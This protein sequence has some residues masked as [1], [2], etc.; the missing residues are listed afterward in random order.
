MTRQEKKYLGALLAAAIV[1]LFVTAAPGD[2]N[3]GDSYKMHFPQLPRNDGWDVCLVDQWL[4]ADF[5]CSESGPITDIHIWFSFLHDMTG[6]IM[7]LELMIYDQSPMGGGPGNML[8]MWNNQGTVTTRVYG[9]G[10]QGFT[11]PAT[12]YVQPP[13][14]HF[15]FFQLNITDIPQPFVQTQGVTYWLVI[16]S[17]S[18]LPDR[19]PG[20]KT[21]QSPFH[22]PGMWS[23]DRIN[24]QPIQLPE[25]LD[26]AFVITSDQ[27]Q[28]DYEFGDA[29]ESA[30][31]YPPLPTLG[32]FP[33]CMTVGPAG[34]I[35]HSNFGAWLGPSFDL[36]TDGNA[37]FCPTFT[38]NQYDR[39]ECFN[40]GDAGLQYPFPYTIVGPAGNEQIVPCP[41]SPGSALGYRCTNA[42]WGQ[43]ID[44]RVHNTMP[45]QAV[46]YVNVLMDWDQNGVWGGTSMCPQGLPAPEH[47]LVNY[48]VPNPYD[49][50]LSSLM[51][52]GTG[53]LIG[54][55][56]GYVWARITITDQFL[57]LGW[58]GEG[59]FEDGET[60]D[61]LLRVDSLLPWDFGDAPE[62][63][64]AYPGFGIMGGFPTCQT[65]G[66]SGWIRHGSTD[67][68]AWFGPMADAE[69]DGNAGFCPVFTPNTYDRD[70]CFADGDAGL[71]IP[72]SYTIQGPVGSESF[73]PCP[74]SLGGY[75][76]RGCTNAGWGV[77]LDIDVT[78]QL[79]SGSTAF[80]NVLMDWNQDGLWSG[81]GSCPFVAAPEHML[82]NFPIPHGFSGPLSWLG[83]PGF[84]IGPKQS[85]FVWA[86]FSITD[87][88]VPTPWTGEGTFEYGETEDYLFALEGEND[89]DF[90]DLPDPPYPTLA[91]NNGA[92]HR[93]VVG[94][95]LGPPGSTLQD[96]EA[97]GQPSGLADGDDLAY[98]DDEDG[99]NFVTVPLIPGQPATVN[100]TN[101]IGPGGVGYLEAW[102]DFNSDGSFGEPGDQILFNQPLSP[103]PVNFD[104]LS[105]NVPLTA[106]QNIDA[107]ARFRFSSNPAGHGPSGGALDGEVEDYRV[108]IGEAATAD[109]GDAPDSTNSQGVMM[110]AY[111]SGGPPG[112]IAN[113]PTVFAGPPSFGPIHRQPR[114]MAY[115]GNWVTL[116]Q[117]A[118]VGLDE[119]P[120]NNIV[121]PIDQ[122]DRDGSDDGVV[123]PLSLPRCMPTAFGYQLTIAS[124][125]ALPMYVN[126]WFDWNR[127]GDW[128]DTMQCPEGPAPEWAVQNQ[129]VLGLPPGIHMLTTPPFVPWHPSASVE[130]QPIWMR[131]SVAEQPWSAIGGPPGYGGSGPLAGYEY[132]ETEDYYFTP[133]IP[134]PVEPKWIQ[135]PHL[136]GDG[137]D[138]ASGYWWIEQTESPVN[139]VVA[140]DF[141]SDGRPIKAL[142]WWGSY[143]DERYAPEAQPD[144]QRVLDGWFLS[145]HWAHPGISIMDCPPNVMFD[146]PPTVLGVYF[147]PVAAVHIERTGFLDCFQRPIYVYTVDLSRCCLLCSELDPR[148]PTDIPPARPEAFFER[149]AARYWLDV[150]SVVGVTWT[151]PACSFADRILTGHV[152]SDITPDGQFWGWHTGKITWMPQGGLAWAC[153]GRI[154]GLAPYPPMCWNYGN[155]TKI[156]WLC[157]S[158]PQ[159][160][161]DMAFVL[162]ADPCAPLGDLNQDGAINGLDVQCMVDCV[163]G[164]TIRTCHCAC[165][166][167]DANHAATYDDIALFVNLLLSQ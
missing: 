155:W 105:F 73:A 138:A 58:T 3:P 54:P 126:V 19:V 61:Y 7:P 26:L 24:W 130:P 4:A 86:R 116:E 74:G 99:V 87:Q 108:R 33:T 9:G 117:E 84:L 30:P 90:G 59:N 32:G 141:I 51:P 121:S 47:V 35:K 136:S 10:P 16:R 132:G 70:E 106:T 40:D 151:P 52:A 29:P 119:D 56:Q 88:P 53:F 143:L 67:F 17:H 80:V 123:V 18:P 161:T 148:F 139:K 101:T 133:E 160:Q 142:R 72:G 39:D 48:P 149:S 14:D 31:A 95:S 146:P 34:W 65:T 13:P 98:F 45:S 68:G 122:P 96:A 82:V 159:P 120:M 163:L 85:G 135:P 115:L 60:E 102:I 110:T 162:F 66:P 124:P 153:E 129:V 158:T 154:I 49:G 21:T 134:P 42:I 152:P 144:P 78:N 23:T 131:I 114:T 156:P 44:V 164:Y 81:S 1:V 103:F 150:V 145:F 62:N 20:W 83:P 75:L 77:N 93:M 43:D 91:V 100:V 94:Y 11:C 137:F 64:I 118:D 38:P 128:D 107:F 92:W 125:V 36:E 69:P 167:M 104:S 97:D 27:S 2:W 25:T 71:L 28:Q 57:P 112:V 46:G 140:D 37:G 76:G 5:D 147:V 79:P 157:P 127:D 6:E 12:G 166:D 89:K 165:G 113:F 50:L 63:A 55:Q 41:G 15:Q 111:P 22:F 8:W 109:L